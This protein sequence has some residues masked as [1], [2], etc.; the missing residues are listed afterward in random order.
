MNSGEQFYWG[1]SEIYN[2]NAI[3]RIPNFIIN[4][5]LKDFIATRYINLTENTKSIG[6]DPKNMNISNF[7]KN[8]SP[9]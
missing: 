9:C 3:I 4:S 6:W 7:S 1:I 2:E 5:Q 8:K